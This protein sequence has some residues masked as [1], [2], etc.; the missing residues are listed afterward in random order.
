MP[1]T[2]ITYR[3]HA[4]FEVGPFRI[5]PYL[6]DHSAY[7]A[8]GLLVEAAGKR[9]FYSGDFRGHGRKAKMFEQFLADPPPDVDLLLMEGTTLAETRRALPRPM[10]RIR[11]LR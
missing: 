10:W 2:I 8:H 4:P 7:D 1:Q 5:T 11:R 6:M 9:L 3:S